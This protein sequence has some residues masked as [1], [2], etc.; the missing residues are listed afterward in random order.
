MTKETVKKLKKYRYRWMQISIDGSTAKA[1]DGL[2]QVAGSWEKAVNAA[3]VVADA[4]IPLAIANTLTP[5]TIDDLP[6]MAQL[7][8][9][10]G[11]SSLITGEVFPSGRGAVNK[12]LLLNNEQR[13]RLWQIIEEQRNL[14]AGRMLVQR[15]MSNRAQLEGIVD[16]PMA[17]VIIRPNGDIRLDCIAP[18]VMGNIA[19]VSFYEEWQKSKNC[20]QDER[21]KAYIESVDLYSGKSGLHQNHVEGDIVL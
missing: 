20:W 10:C 9:S 2:R 5:A 6:N 1:H 8:Y 18:F 17:G 13:G 7:A 12:D 3:L 19:A 14:F 15:S 4:G 11:A 16:L 21:V